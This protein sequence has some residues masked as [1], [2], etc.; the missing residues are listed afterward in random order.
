[1]PDMA[2]QLPRA[3]LT[4]LAGTG[5]MMIFEQPDACHDLVLGAIGGGSSHATKT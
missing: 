2:V 5:H 1:M 4:R 3:R